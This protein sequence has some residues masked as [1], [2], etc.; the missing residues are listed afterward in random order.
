MVRNMSL[1]LDTFALFQL[2]VGGEKGDKV[3]K[4]LKKD[5][6]VYISAL[7]F[8]EIGTAITKQINRKKAEEYLRSI[9]VYYKIL[10]VNEKVALKA[11]ELH[12]RYKL[13]AIDCMVYATAIINN[14]KVVS[15]CRHFKGIS[16]PR[17]VIVV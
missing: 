9:R 7:S 10:D 12:R 8:Y 15:G 13:P 3:K 16:S 2:F 11:I 1:V 6:N 4:I 5:T 17:N 14:A